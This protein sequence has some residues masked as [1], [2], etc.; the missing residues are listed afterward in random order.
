MD[1]AFLLSDGGPEDGAR[2]RMMEKN[3]RV[4]A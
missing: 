4:S 1:G 3:E 2:A